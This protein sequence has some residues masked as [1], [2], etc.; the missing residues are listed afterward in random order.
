[1]SHVRQPLREHMDRHRWSVSML[2]DEVGVPASHLRSVIAGST[3]PRRELREQ[4]PAI[5]G[6]PLAELFTADL[7][8]RDWSGTRGQRGG[9]KAVAH[10]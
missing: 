2:A 1:M 3:S 6:V 4:L 5:F 7:L 8:S 10:V 9:R